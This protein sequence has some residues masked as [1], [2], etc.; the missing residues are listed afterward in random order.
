MG[1]DEEWTGRGPGAGEVEEEMMMEYVG[2]RNR[3]LMFVR[4]VV[5]CEGAD[6]AVRDLRQL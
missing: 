6:C 2:Q 1:G 3:G 5:S 4:Y